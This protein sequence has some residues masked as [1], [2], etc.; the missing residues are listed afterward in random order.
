MTIG[1][2]LVTACQ[3][4]RWQVLRNAMRPQRQACKASQGTRQR[5]G[6]TQILLV[7]F[8][9]ST[10]TISTHYDDFRDT[11]MQMGTGK[12]RE[13]TRS[14]HVGG[15]FCG[16]VHFDQAQGAISQSSRRSSDGMN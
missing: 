4:P 3:P 7:G 2:T 12:W 5:Q 13:V 11:R 15:E 14:G 8:W 1:A 6:I 10:I 9:S 16:T